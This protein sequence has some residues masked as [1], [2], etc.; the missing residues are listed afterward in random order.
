MNLVLAICAVSA[1]SW[2]ITR[3]VLFKE[4]RSWAT[5]H[6][7]IFYPLTCGYCLAPWIALVI[8]IAWRIDWRQYFLIVWLSYLNL[9]LMAKL[10][11]L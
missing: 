3:E 11:G 8:L 2:I 9:G 10:R 4:L 1:V 6:G 7:G 5:K